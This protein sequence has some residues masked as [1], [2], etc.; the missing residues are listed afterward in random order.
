MKNYEFHVRITSV[1]Y[2]RNTRTVQA[3]S[4][5]EAQKLIEEKYADDDGFQLGIHQ[6]KLDI[7]ECDT[8]FLPVDTR[9]VPK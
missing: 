8:D 2:T 4:L 5:E 7:E 6:E 1:E 3:N 9:P